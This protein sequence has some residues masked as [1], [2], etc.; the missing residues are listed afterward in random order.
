MSNLDLAD[1]TKNC[2]YLE[3]S[4]EHSSDSVK[5][6]GLNE[7]DRISKQ[8][9][10]QIFSQNIVIAVIKCLENT[11]EKAGILAVKI[12]PKILPKLLA[13]HSIHINL[14]RLLTCSDLIRCRVYDVC[15]AT[16]KESQDN[17]ENVAYVIDRLCSDLDT[18]DILL[19]LNILEFL[20]DLAQTNHG[21]LYLDNK[22]IFKRI[23]ENVDSLDNN[24]LKNLLFPGYVKF[25][26]N[27]ALKQPANVIQG[28]PIFINSL[29]DLLLECI[30]SDTDGTTLPVIFD[31]LGEIIDLLMN[32][33]KY[34]KFF[35]FM[36]NNKMKN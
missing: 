3:R 25:F 24:P 16:A 30:V 21:W 28:F 34:L 31:T 9:P 22:G 29:L 19:E 5:V 12:L 4:L 8:A 35:R 20:S 18:N 27:V 14:N 13:D 36:S 17:L 6:V 2:Y 11:Q 1:T 32:N 33:K 10:N 23:T 15:V 26:G 7:I